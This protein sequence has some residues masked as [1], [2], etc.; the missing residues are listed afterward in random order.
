M[1]LPLPTEAV[2]LPLVA[3]PGLRAAAGGVTGPPVPSHLV[4]LAEALGR[5][6]DVHLLTGADADP[7][8]AGA[9]DA[10]T[11]GGGALVTT[12]RTPDQAAHVVRVAREHD[13]AVAVPGDG[14]G[15]AGSLD[16]AVLVSTAA[17]DH[18]TVLP[19]L[20]RAHVGVGA[21]WDDL[22]AAAACFG[23]VPV[24][25]GP[26]VRVVGEVAGRALDAAG[27]AEPWPGGVR[28]VDVVTGDGTLRRL[29][30]AD[31]PERIPAARGATGARGVVV[32][33]ELDLVEL[34]LVEREL[35]GRDPAEPAAP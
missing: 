28:A 15:A 18:L 9:A 4:A 2:R 22:V 29:T 23:L 30:R 7:D 20:A 3:R 25:A 27:R 6:V 16:G 19:V 8:L 17:L 13:A 5:V 10:V 26:P 33:L 12:P 21:R 24:A 34:D 1:Y 14:A 35:D 31:G 32:A 11:G